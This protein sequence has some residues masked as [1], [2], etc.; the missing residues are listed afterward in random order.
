MTAYGYCLEAEDTVDRTAFPA[1]RVYRGEPEEEEEVDS[2]VD[3]PALIAGLGLVGLVLG[4]GILRRRQVVRR[5]E[6]RRRTR[7]R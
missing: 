3:K 7:R 2:F 6:A 4:A 1:A 5:R